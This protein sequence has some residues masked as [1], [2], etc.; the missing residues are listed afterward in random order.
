MAIIIGYQMQVKNSACFQLA[1]K[2]IFF[3]YKESRYHMAQN[4]DRIK[5]IDKFDKFLSIHQHLPIKIFH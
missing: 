2:K 1:K 4:F 5:N 3:L